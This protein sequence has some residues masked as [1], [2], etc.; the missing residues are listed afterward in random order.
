MPVLSAHNLIQVKPPLGARE[1]YRWQHEKLF[2]SQYK[3]RIFRILNKITTTD[4]I[5]NCDLK[6][7]FTHTPLPHFSL[8]LYIC[9][10][11]RRA[12][13][14][15]FKKALDLLEYINEVTSWTSDIIALVLVQCFHHQFPVAGRC[16]RHR[17]IEVWDFWQSAQER[18]VRSFCL[19][20]FCLR[21]STILCADWL[22]SLP[23]FTQ[24]VHSWRNRW[25]SGSRQRQ[26]L[27][28]DTPQTYAGRSEMLP[29]LHLFY[30]SKPGRIKAY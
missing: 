13:E 1:T 22:F 28:Q 26:H 25:P 30:K 27:C 10:D 2:L 3:I 12:N 8:Q 24:L 5:L 18:R 7:L 11:N 4:T 9:D 19:L 23:L 16:R 17:N 21:W 6:R 15:D 29:E 14:Y 20:D